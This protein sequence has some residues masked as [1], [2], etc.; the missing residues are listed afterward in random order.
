MERYPSVGWRGIYWF[1]LAMEASALICWVLFYFP[2]SFQ[3]K[4]RFEEHRSALYWAKNFDWFG[5]FLMAGGFVAFLLGLSWGGVVYPWKSAA[6]IASIVVGFCV[7]VLFV[8]WEIYAPLKEPLIPMHLFKNGKWVISCILLGLG[9]GVYYAFA[10]IWPA[11]CATLY[12]SGD[13]T[14]LGGISSL[15]GVGIISGQ[16]I[17]GLLAARIGKTKYQCMAVF[18]I[19]G[20][21]LACKSTLSEVP[22]LLTALLTS[23]SYCG[24]NPRQQRSRDCTSVPWLFLYWLE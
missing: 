22:W 23:H 2:P 1:I 13:L 6:T 18:T 14:Y 16:I 15:V 19:G 4:H 17:G 12:N 9:A 8:L 5:F 24:D 10:I 20:A 7:M 21:F 11:Q 3:K